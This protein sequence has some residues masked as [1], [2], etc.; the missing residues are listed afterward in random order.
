MDAAQLNLLY[1]TEVRWLSKG[2]ILKRVLD[3]KVEVTEF[4]ILHHKHKW[5]ALFSDDDWCYGLCYLVDIFEKLNLLNLSLQGKGAN[6]IKF[7][8]KLASFQA[9][10][11]LWLR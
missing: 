7:S 2:N 11:S 6:L 9:M 10:I 3:L 1:Y 8:D 5:A 4:L